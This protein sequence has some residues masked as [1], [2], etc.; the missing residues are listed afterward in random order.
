[1]LLAVHWR[2][3]SLSQLHPART[4]RVVLQQQTRALGLANMLIS[5][6]RWYNRTTTVQV[7]EYTTVY[8]SG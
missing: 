1:M 6:N 2:G 4:L 3:S 5:H 7:E 8:E